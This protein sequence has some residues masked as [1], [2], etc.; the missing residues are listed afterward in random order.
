MNI[1]F[2]KEESILTE[3]LQQALITNNHQLLL[4]QY[5]EVIKHG[6]FLSKYSHDLLNKYILTLF[7]IR[8][9]EKVINIVED[10]LRIGV[11]DCNWYF[12]AFSILVA[13][14]DIYYAKSLI[15]RSTLLND[16]SLK[17][18]I[19]EDDG[20]YNQLLSLHDSLLYSITP[21]LIMINFINEL[22]IESFKTKIDEDYII[23]RYFDLLN[24]LFE[25]GVDEEFLDI[26]RNCLE[27]LYEIDI[28]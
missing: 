2:P 8:E 28:L 10:L 13:R 3:Q 27:T 23:M 9:F 26:F 19:N 15:N 11:E 22:L 6:V 21:C 12:Y 25:Y 16:Q 7:D 20:N 5:D 18:L 17:S 14:K 4:K 1:K 24:L